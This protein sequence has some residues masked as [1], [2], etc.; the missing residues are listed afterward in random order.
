MLQRFWLLAAASGLAGRAIAPWK[1][2]L[3]APTKHTCKSAIEDKKKKGEL[4]SEVKAERPYTKAGAP[5][6]YPGEIR[7]D[8]VVLD[9]TGKVTKVFDFNSTAAPKAR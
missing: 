3:P 9:G 7:P 1:A 2:A 4:P 8:V 5:A 6:T